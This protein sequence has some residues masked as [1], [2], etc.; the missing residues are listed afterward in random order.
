[1][2][3][4]DD[5]SLPY[6]TTNVKSIDELKISQDENIILVLGSEGDGV[7]KTINKL[8]DYRIMIPP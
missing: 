3:E 2:G 7:S 1:M 4:E 6:K 8:A 5:E